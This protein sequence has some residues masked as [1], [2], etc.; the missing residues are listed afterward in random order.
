MTT[1][2]DL[3]VIEAMRAAFD[4]V[5][6]EPATE[7]R[8]DHDEFLVARCGGEAYLF[9]LAELSGFAAGRRIVPL[10]SQAPHLL[11]VTGIRGTVTPVY[12]LAALLGHAPVS[13]PPKWL[14]VA[15]GGRLGLGFDDFGGHVRSSRAT[16]VQPPS[17]RATARIGD[18]LHQLVALAPLIADLERDVRASARSQE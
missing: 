5:F 3:A 10:P 2:R 7:R 9:A 1:P 12:D 18:T 15:G 4:R 16:W 8:V 11:G 17:G 13:A 14:M 6:A